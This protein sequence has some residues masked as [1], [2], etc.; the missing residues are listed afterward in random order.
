MD[1]L[2]G[3]VAV[4]E[5]AIS[6]ALGSLAAV[7]PSAL[8]RPTPCPEWDLHDLLAHLYD[9]M[10]SLQEAVDG[11]ISP[12]PA[13]LSRDV[14]PQVRDRAVGLLG[15][16][17]SA[18]GGPVAILSES[19]TA[20][21]VAGAGAIEVT[22]HGWDVSRACGVLRPIPDELASE[23]LDLSDVLVTSRDRPERFAWPLPAVAGAS[24]GERL[25]AFL[26]RSA[27]G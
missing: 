18:G 6:Y 9:S 19:M 10:A 11:R 3:G 2:V 16:W 7:T 20:P 4:L 22:I 26:G 24:A 5:R 12:T 8:D 27:S 15:S 13:C 1:A 14:I 21:L 25:L 23:L 17:A